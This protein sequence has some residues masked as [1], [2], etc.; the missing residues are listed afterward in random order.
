[1]RELVLLRVLVVLVLSS[2]SLITWFMR[3]GWV[4][5]SLL[6][7]KGGLVTTQGYTG[8]NEWYLWT[9]LID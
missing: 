6:Y 3:I 1:M 9:G 2:Y 7:I 8:I 4:F 5:G